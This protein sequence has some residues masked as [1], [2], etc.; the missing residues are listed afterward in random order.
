MHPL[1]ASQIA[2]NWASVLLP[3]NGDDSIDW[4]RL[5]NQVDA[6]IAFGVNGIYTN[7]TTGEF[8]SQTESE[9]DRLSRTVAER[10][11]RAG[12]PFQL[13]ACHVS[14]QLTLERI[15]RSRQL[16]PGAIQ[17]TLPDW[18]PPNDDETLA[19]MVKFA[20]A[21]APVGLVLYNPPHA[22][23]RLQPADFGRLR[24]A[25][26]NLVGIKVM[27]GDAEWYAAMRTEAAGL[28]VFVPGHHLATGWPQGAAGAYSN[29]ACLQPRGAQR[30]YETMRRCPDA[31]LDLEK[32][33]QK[34]MQDRIL[35]FREEQGFSNFALDKL[36]AAI[37]AWTD[38][39]TR[40]R[41]PYRSIP[42][43]EAERLRP[44]ARELMPEL[45]E[46]A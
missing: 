19:A 20:E 2:G 36:L 39:G 45:F 35:P 42:A 1:A 6:L 32:R 16:S 13:G 14:P 8:W 46:A 41:W 34:F 15:R 33:V 12:L 24:R 37:G 43:S 28:S 40:V 11:E 10:C 30:W 3:V 22:K 23:R 27:D 21:A 31:A 38:A 7:G 17:V 26:P 4:A 29:V 44:G 18:W 9:F 5:E 25:L